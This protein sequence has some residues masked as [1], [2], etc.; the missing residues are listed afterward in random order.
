MTPSAVP[1]LETPRL[2]LVPLGFEHVPLVFSLGCDADISA[3]LAVDRQQSLAEARRLVARSLVSQA[4]GGYYEWA[5]FCRKS[6]ALLGLCRLGP[7]DA[8]RGSAE[9]GY[10]LSRT[11]WGHG[12]ATEATGAAVSFG[13]ER[14]RLRAIEALVLA[15]NAPSRRVLDKLGLSRVETRAV[16]PPEDQRPA[17][18]WRIERGRHRVRGFTPFL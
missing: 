10:M 11:H 8:A 6:S 1:G 18:L 15:S 14:L 5:L 17:E 12:Y 3:S 4:A 13:F 16:D 2:S 7:T 9:L